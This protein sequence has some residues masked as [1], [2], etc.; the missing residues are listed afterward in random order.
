MKIRNII[1]AGFFLILNANAQT[2]ESCC[3]Y[4][5][6][7]VIFQASTPDK[8]V[9][10]RDSIELRFQLINRSKE[11]IFVFQKLAESISVFYDSLCHKIYVNL[12]FLY[13][14]DGYLIPQI[15]KI[16][17]GK[18]VLIDLLIPTDSIHSLPW[19]VT[20]CPMQISFTTFFTDNIYKYI[21][22]YSKD[23]WEVINSSLDST[24]VIVTIG[25][26]PIRMKR[27]GE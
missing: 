15:L 5:H 18:E 9:L 1:C 8:Y 11:A 6:N 14:A 7:E 23:Q 19:V 20:S 10:V 12:D 21:R 16:P 3:R 22:P 26:L 4:I 27:R 2:G 24:C 17:S 25:D 13:T